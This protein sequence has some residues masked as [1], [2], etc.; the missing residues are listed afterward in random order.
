MGV[1]VFSLEA[2]AD[3]PGDV[4]H[5]GVR[6]GFVGEEENWTPTILLTVFTNSSAPAG[7]TAIWR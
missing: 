7:G 4:D 5:R 3:R 2:A 6:D 1:R